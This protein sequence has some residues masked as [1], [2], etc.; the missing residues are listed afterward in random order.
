MKVAE[1]SLPQLTHSI[2]REVWIIGG[3]KKG[4][5]AT[6]RSIGH[7]SSKVSLF[8]YHTLDVKNVHLCTECFT[9][10]VSSFTRLIIPQCRDTPRWESFGRGS[11][12]TVQ[13]P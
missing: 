5:R 13:D 2:G 4:Y 12:G 10:L 8:G 11:T 7:D 9:F 1:F 6:L 3:P